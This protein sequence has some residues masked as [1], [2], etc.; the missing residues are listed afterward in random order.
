MIEHVKNN[1]ED[2]GIIPT[3]HKGNGRVNPEIPPICLSHE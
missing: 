2:D 3:F 1:L